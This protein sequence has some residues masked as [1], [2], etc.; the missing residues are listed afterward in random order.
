MHAIVGPP[1]DMTEARAA[2][3]RE[4]R[5]AAMFA[6]G[7]SLFFFA[8]TALTPPPQQLASRGRAVVV[9]AAPVEAIAP[10][11]V[12]VPPVAAPAVI[13][14]LPERPAPVVEAATLEQPAA[15]AGGPDPAAQQAARVELQTTAEP[16]VA[17]AKVEPPAAEPPAVE[18]PVVPQLSLA[19]IPPETPPTTAAPTN[20]AR[21]AHP[22]AADGAPEAPTASVATPEPAAVVALATPQPVRRRPPPLRAQ[23]PQQRYQD[24]AQ[25]ETFVATAL[26]V[27]PT[28]VALVRPAPIAI[29]RPPAVRDAPQTEASRPTPQMP[30]TAL[31]QPLPAELPAGPTPV[32]A[33]GQAG[34][35][36]DMVNGALLRLRSNGIKP[37]PYGMQRIRGWNDGR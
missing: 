17:M 34:I 36:D 14:A 19:D 28:P 25:P 18:A 8:Y 9:A 35:V 12:P 1:P 21:E 37:P 23:A 31:R 27:A 7:A 22:V 30:R 15:P 33:A 10:V 4:I 26:Q 2:L 29:P 13:A 32:V 3:A 6:V 20:L 5:P 16:P 11:L 24:G